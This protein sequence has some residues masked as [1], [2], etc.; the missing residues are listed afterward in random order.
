MNKIILCFAEDRTTTA[1]AKKVRSFVVF[2]AS[3]CGVNRNTFNRYFNIIQEKIL[4][5]G[6]K[7]IETFELDE[8]YFEAKCVRGKLKKG[9][10]GFEE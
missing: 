7:E 6:L 8:S 5:E 3:N 2:V 10:S 4:K 1:T 9:E